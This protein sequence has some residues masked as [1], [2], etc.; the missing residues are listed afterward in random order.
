MSRRWLRAT[1]CALVLALS[2]PVQAG[3]VAAPATF[4]IDP[5]C[6]LA[7]PNLHNDPPFAPLLITPPDNPAEPSVD[8]RTDDGRTFEWEFRDPNPGDSQSSYAFR[9]RLLENPPQPPIIIFGTS[10]TSTEGGGSRAAAADI[11]VPEWWDAA[12]GQWVATEVFNPGSLHTL[13]FPEGSWENRYKY[14]WTVA[15]R[16][17]FG[18]QGPYADE[19]TVTGNAAPDAPT[20]MSPADGGSRF[21]NPEPGVPGS[22]EPAQREFVWQFQDPDE[23]DFQTRWMFRRTSS[24]PGPD[25]IEYWNSSTKVWQSGEAVNTIAV[26]NS[27]P[28]PNEW[29][30]VFPANQGSDGSGTL[31]WSNTITYEWTVRTKDSFQAEGPPADDF[32]VNPGSEVDSVDSAHNP[33]QPDVQLAASEWITSVRFSELFPSEPLSLGAKTLAATVSAEDRYQL[34]VRGTNFEPNQAVSLTFAPGFGEEVF[35]ATADGA[36][37][38]A[39]PI[40]PLARPAGIYTA[41]IVDAIGHVAEAKFFV[42]CASIE[43]TPKVVRRGF[44][45]SVQGSGFI[46]ASGVELTWNAG[47]GVTGVTADSSGNFKT[48]ML[49]MRGDLLGTRRL[50]ART[51]AEPTFPQPSDSVLIVSGPAQPRDFLLRS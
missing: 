50:R 39:F 38:F 3:H 4:S 37:A 36:G 17:S 35:T 16:D 40:T 47:I 42:P 31:T 33:T 20:L 7:G 22:G 32:T 14:A 43:V 5:G 8:F 10:S 51:P 13:V 1:L 28:S 21:F 23:D 44:V 34:F 27:G 18:L 24:V 48:T 19:F 30:Y 12:S 9:R 11:G 2:L 26:L 25:V 46:P 49:L 15:T 6:G 41:R 45:V 29:R